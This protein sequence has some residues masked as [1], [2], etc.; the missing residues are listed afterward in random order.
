[1]KNNYELR[2]LSLIMGVL[3]IKVKI[4]NLGFLVKFLS[5]ILSYYELYY[6][7]DVRDPDLVKL[8]AA[9]RV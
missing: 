9:D 3:T 2:N 1:M 6:I 5:N 7:F 4:V 8:T